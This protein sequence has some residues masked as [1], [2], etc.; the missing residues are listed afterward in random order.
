V[1]VREEQE[2]A[3]AIKSSLSHTE[4]AKLKKKNFKL[5]HGQKQKKKALG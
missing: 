3:V 1:C 2:S 4:A 5:T